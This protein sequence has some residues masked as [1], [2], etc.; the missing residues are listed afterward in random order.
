V[1]QLSGYLFSCLLG[2]LISGSASATAVDSAAI[3]D[4]GN[5]WLNYGRDYT[6]QRYSPLQQINTSNVERLGLAWSFT[7]P[8]QRVMESTPLLHEGVLY[9]TSAWSR[10]FALDA[11]T[12]A[13]LWEFDPQ[14]PK[15]H[16]INSCCGPANRGLAIWSVDAQAL[17]FVGSFD[18]R[19]IALDAT[20]GEQRWSVQT[21]PENSHY[22]ITGAPRVVNG[23]VIIGNGGAELGVRG[24]VSAYDAASGELVWRFYT[25]PGD[26]AKAQDN[27]AL[28][29][30]VTTWNGKWWQVG[31]GGGTVWDAMAYD[32]ELDLLYIGT[33]I[34]T[35][36][37]PAAVITST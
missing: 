12:G 9:T 10:V 2:L 28:E 23:K 4:P 6:E 32:P 7:Y 22:T 11:A 21:V 31:G 29:Q 19:L 13:L 16:L 36:A 34:G 24:Y 35:S 37:V 5:E 15:S 3:T 33:G 20:T 26:P 18:G 17:V 8:T 30:A 25:V 14:V 27:K 1:N